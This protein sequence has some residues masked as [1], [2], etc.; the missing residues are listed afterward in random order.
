MSTEHDNSKPDQQATEVY[1]RLVSETD[2]PKHGIMVHESENG[3]AYVYAAPGTS[4]VMS[5]LRDLGYESIGAA[6]ADGFPDE[7][8][9]KEAP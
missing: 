3:V 6:G 4:G 1:R 9:I 8:H 5:A 7:F 2:V